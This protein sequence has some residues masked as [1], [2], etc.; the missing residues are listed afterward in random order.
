MPETKDMVLVSCK[1][2]SGYEYVTRAYYN[3]EENYWTASGVIAWMPLPEPY[4]KG[5]KHEE[6]N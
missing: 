5:M 1:L 3:E 4:Y 2:E 6:D